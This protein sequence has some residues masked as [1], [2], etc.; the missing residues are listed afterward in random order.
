MSGFGTASPSRSKRATSVCRM[1]TPRSRPSTR[2]RLTA[3]R[4]APDEQRH[5]ECSLNSE[6][7]CTHSRIP[8]AATATTAAAQRRREILRGAGTR[9]KTDQHAD[10]RAQSPPVNAPTRRASRHPSGPKSE[11]NT[12][13]SRPA[14]VS[15][16]TTAATAPRLAKSIASVRILRASR[17]RLSRMPTAPPS[18]RRRANVT[19]NQQIG[20]PFAQ[21]MSSTI[22]DTPPS[23]SVTRTSLGASGPCPRI[24]DAASTVRVI[25]ASERRLLPIES[26]HL[27][28]GNGTRGARRQ[29]TDDREPR[30]RPILENA[31]R[32]APLSRR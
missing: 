23:H 15:A 6:Q 16:M 31:G 29:P 25:A 20:A 13:R 11:T 7:R 19:P 22:A 8:T 27:F 2:R 24:T 17:D 18:R 32:R 14:P 26:G 21:A 1:S 9:R 30:G 4:P 5:A 3:N 28:F 10:P 12:R